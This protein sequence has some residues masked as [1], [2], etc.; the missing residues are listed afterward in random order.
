MILYQILSHQNLPLPDEVP[1]HPAKPLSVDLPYNQKRIVDIYIDDSI[2]VALDIDN[3]MLQ[4]V[5]AIPLAIN[6]MARP[7]DSADIIPRKHIISMK[8][9][10]AE[11]QLE[12]EK[13]VLGWILNTRSLK[14]SLPIDKL[15]D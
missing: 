10:Q 8:K 3:N 7:T 4:L 15:R 1:F 12:E 6:T 11:G 5:R 13:K 9:F 2:G 14:L